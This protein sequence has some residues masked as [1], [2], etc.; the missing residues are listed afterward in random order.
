MI[1]PQPGALVTVSACLHFAGLD[2]AN[3]SLPL[4][5]TVL[6]LCTHRTGNSM[7][8]MRTFVEGVQDIID[9]SQFLKLSEHSL[10]GKSICCAG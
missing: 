9:V 3:I 10:I 8:V 6:E 2:I 4:Q 7:I 5:M 1:Q